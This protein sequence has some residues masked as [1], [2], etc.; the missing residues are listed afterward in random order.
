MFIFGAKAA[1]GYHLAKTIIYAINKLAARVNGKRIKDKL[2]IVF[3]PNYRVSLAE[4][5]V[6]QPMSPS[7]SR[8]PVSKPPVPAI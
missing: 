3:P 1:P 2:K 8:P 7:R 4:K 6:L 5:I